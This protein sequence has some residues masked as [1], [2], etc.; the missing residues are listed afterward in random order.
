M[1]E[2]AD[3]QIL[4]WTKDVLGETI[5][6]LNPSAEQ[7]R[8]SRGVGIRLLEILPEPRDRATARTRL[9]LGLKY[10]V[11][12]WAESATEAHRILGQLFEAAMQHPEFEIQPESPSAA[13][14]QAFGVAPQPCLMLR[15][16]AWKE[17]E[18]KPAK[19]VRKVV[20]DTVLGSALRGVVVG[21]EGIPIC[22]ASVELP[23]LNLSTRTDRRGEF[24]FENVPSSKTPRNLLIRARGREMTISI[25]DQTSQSPLSIN[26]E[27]KE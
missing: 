15:T 24:E 7:Q 5:A 13:F 27:M 14:W 3:S 11:T 21:P 19:M 25:D 22:D 4:Q 1:I 6:S 17:L 2:E 23:L 8:A 12:S 9:Q 16:R 26:F 20:L 18:T 10:L